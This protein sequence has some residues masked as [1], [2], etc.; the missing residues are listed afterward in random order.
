ML[1]TTQTREKI[2]NRIFKI[3]RLANKYD[4]ISDDRLRKQIVSKENATLEESR[5]LDDYIKKIN[6][7]LTRINYDTGFNTELFN[8]ED[9]YPSFTPMPTEQI[10]SPLSNNDYTPSVPSSYS[11]YPPPFNN[12]S[13]MTKAS[14]VASAFNRLYDIFTLTNSQDSLIAL[15]QQNMFIKNRSNKKIKNNLKEQ[16]NSFERQVMNLHPQ[17]FN[18]SNQLTELPESNI[19]E[20]DYSEDVVDNHSVEEKQTKKKIG[21]REAKESVFDLLR[22][23]LEN[24]NN[25][26]DLVIEAPKDN[27]FFM[28]YLDSQSISHFLNEINSLKTETQQTSAVLQ[29]V[30]VFYRKLCENAYKIRTLLI[31]TG[32]SWDFK[33]IKKIKDVFEY[34]IKNENPLFIDDFFIINSEKFISEIAN[35]ARKIWLKENPEE[36]SIGENCDE[37]LNDILTS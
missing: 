25:E 6:F 29:E 11:L 17:L 19:Q 10:S 36:D 34:Q 3:M 4:S 7:I 27:G 2:V 16:T 22:G 9:I 28:K 33:E 18:R 1:L 26:K 8:Y 31:K 30:N 15:E 32:A 5:S 20:P 14:G 21:I 23:P 24:L 12:K 35:K 13:S 37:L